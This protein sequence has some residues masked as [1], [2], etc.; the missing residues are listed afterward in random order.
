LAGDRKAFDKWTRNWGVRI[1]NVSIV[2]VET[3]DDT[4][5][6][7]GKVF[8]TVLPGYSSLKNSAS[9]LKTLEDSP[10]QL[11]AA[12]TIEHKLKGITVTQS[13]TQ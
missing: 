13:P 1:K 7:D 2:R 3:E 4:V 12:N 10:Y 8:Y 9:I 6:W 5:G 11:V